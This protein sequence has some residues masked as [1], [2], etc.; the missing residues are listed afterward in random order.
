MKVKKIIF[1]AF[2]IA[3]FSSCSIHE[4]NK[5]KD[6]SI[7]LRLLKETDEAGKLKYVTVDSCKTNVDIPIVVC[8]NIN[9]FP[10][11]VIEQISL[12]YLKKYIS[13]AS[14]NELV[15]FY[16][17]ERVKQ[18][19]WQVVVNPDVVPHDEFSY[20]NSINNSKAGKEYTKFVEDINRHF[21]INKQMLSYFK[22]KNIK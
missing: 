1:F 9:D 14:A 17:Q 16:G 2:S 15:Q 19:S 12:P 18:L 20:L 5:T 4:V 13:E 21:E 6:D 11:E 8:K 22:N 10:N 7:Y 3:L